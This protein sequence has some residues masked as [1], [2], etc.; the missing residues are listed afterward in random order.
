[1]RTTR[2]PTVH[3]SVSPPDV[4]TVGGKSSSEVNKFEQV[5]RDGHQMSLAGG[6]MTDVWGGAGVGACIPWVIVT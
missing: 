6:P 4:S 2:L 5:P 3:A 1:M